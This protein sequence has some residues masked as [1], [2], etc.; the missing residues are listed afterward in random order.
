MYN[1]KETD[2]IVLCSF[3]QISYKFRYKLLSGLESSKPDF[4]KYAP[5]LIKSLGGGVYNKVREAFYSGAYRQKVLKKLE[6]KGI[7]CV[8]VFSE[9]Y[10]QQLKN[11]PAPPLVLY[12][13]G[14]LSL[15]SSRCFGVVGSRRTQTNILKKCAEISAQIAS[16]FTVVT[17][18]ADGA[19]TAAAEGALKSGNLISVLAYGFDYCYPSCNAALLKKIVKNG[20][21]ITEFSPSTSPQAYYFPLRNRIIAGISEGVLVVSAGVRSGALITANYAI[22]YGR[23][24]FAFPYGIG[25]TCGAGCN[26][27]IKKG[28]TLTE[29]ILDIF[30]PFGLDFKQPEKK[31]LSNEESALLAIIRGQGEIFVAELAEKTGKQPFE[32]IPAL[33]SLEIKGLITRMGG[34]RYSAV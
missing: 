15:L 6:E 8:T 27:L 34:N 20:L 16:E 13:R 1:E 30:S 2:L 19:D 25:V 10:P 18:L 21:V 24:V 32:L 5:E 23:E 3:G 7:I 29:N 17:G 33:S 28:G 26:L 12:C 9:N 4:V 31:A 22:D 14:N 11:T